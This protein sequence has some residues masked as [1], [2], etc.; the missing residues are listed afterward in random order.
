[1]TDTAIVILAIGDEYL[2]YW[3]KYCEASCRAYAAKHNYDL[4]LI[5]EPLDNSPR[6]QARSPAWQKCLVLSQDFSQKYERIVSLDGDIV[7]NSQ[8]APR[9]TDQSPVDRVGGVISGSH[10][11]E[12]L[13]GVLADRLGYSRGEYARGLRNWESM[14]KLAYAYH[15]LKPLPSV[16]QT[17]VLVASP[18]HHRSIFESIYVAPEYHVSRC[19]EQVPLSHA[20]LTRDLF[21]AIDTRFNSVFH[22]T[23]L[24]HYPYLLDKG[25][26]NLDFAVYCALTTE[27][28]NNFFLHFAY[29]RMMA[30]HLVQ[31]VPAAT[32]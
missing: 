4:I 5:C 16:I 3:R 25:L 13:R 6:A 7:I 8:E 21:C 27:L 28:A 2:A 29:D 19:Y 14:Q 31:N 1:M 30:R 9:I 20:L 24:V 15:G 32:N 23:A 17:G 26:P 18:V 12:D 22:E 10:I 11:H